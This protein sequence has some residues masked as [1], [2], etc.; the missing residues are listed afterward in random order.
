MGLVGHPDLAR[1]HSGATARRT[2]TGA[3]RAALFASGLQRSDRPTAELAA[4]AIAATVG[5]FGIHGCVRRMAQE[6]GEH[7]DAAAERMRWICQL[8]AEIPASP[9]MPAGGGRAGSRT[10]NG[11]TQ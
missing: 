2:V 6:F 10:R 11:V 3:R 4:Q 5:Q 7:P 9:Q 8:V 1:T